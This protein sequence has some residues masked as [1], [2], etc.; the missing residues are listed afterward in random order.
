MVAAWQAHADGQLNFRFD[1][2]A[3]PITTLSLTVPQG[4][5]PVAS[6]GSFRSLKSKVIARSTVSCWVVRPT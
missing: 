3:C 6:A 1:M 2:P 4:I 5:V